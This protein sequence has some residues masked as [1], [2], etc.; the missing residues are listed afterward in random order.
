V[1][2]KYANYWWN[3]LFVI[4]LSSVNLN[5]TPFPVNISNVIKHIISKRDVNYHIALPDNPH[6]LSYPHEA[7]F[8]KG[9]GKNN[10]AD[11]VTQSMNHSNLTNPPN[12]LSLPNRT[13]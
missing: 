11:V 5:L 13:V 10:F 8:Q 12:V 7:V 1:E 3:T 2:Y 4:S 6:I 9:Q